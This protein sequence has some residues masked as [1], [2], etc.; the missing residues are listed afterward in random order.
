MAAGIYA[1]LITY[2][3]AMTI[4]VLLGFVLSPLAASILPGRGGHPPGHRRCCHSERCWRV[5]ERR[6]SS[7]IARVPFFKPLAL[8]VAGVGL[9]AGVVVMART[10][11]TQGRISETATLVIVIGIIALL[12]AASSERQR[13][14]L[15]I[16]LPIVLL[17][18]MQFAIVSTQLSRRVRVAGRAVAARQHP[19]R[20]GAADGGVR[21]A[22]GSAVVFH[23]PA[24]GH[25][26]IGTCTNYY[27]PAYWRFYTTKHGRE[28]LVR[29][30]EVGRR[31]G[32]PAGDP[33][34]Q[35]GARQPRGPAFPAPVGQRRAAARRHSRN[36]SRILLHDRRSVITAPAESPKAFARP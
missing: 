29:E 18:A 31:E 3:N 27:L 12:I 30:D 32:R 10:A 9:A 33:G 13:H 7:R 34:G 6:S 11:M 36:R 28:D 24:S 16:V 20:V 19:G 23:D 25:A 26:A 8:T 35:P 17:I 15:L 1:A 4:V 5:W 21:S 2:R 14:G 22:A